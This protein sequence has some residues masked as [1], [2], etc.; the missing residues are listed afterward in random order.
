MTVA[1]MDQPPHIRQNIANANQEMTYL[2]SAIRLYQSKN[3]KTPNKLEDLIPNPLNTLPQDPFTSLSFHYSN[4]SSEIVLY[5]FG[6]DTTDD[7]AQLLYDPTNGM[8]SQG[9]ILV[10]LQVL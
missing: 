7:H 4:Q 1:N 10:R 8:M 2:A 6:P 3:H 9:D 5:S